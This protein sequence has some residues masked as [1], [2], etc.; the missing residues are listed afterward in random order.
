M[1]LQGLGPRIRQ[2][3]Q[4]KRWRQEQLAQKTSLS[5]SY[6][7]MLERGEKLPKLSTFVR[8]ANA[9]EV[10]ADELL[11]DVLDRG[12]QIKVSQYTD[13]IGS[14]PPVEQK[15]IY[16]VLDTLLKNP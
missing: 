15:R 4:A 12:Y 16:D 7:G 14:L 9:L 3:R 5:V 8:I 13:R 6:I 11:S 1:S 10:T 2:F